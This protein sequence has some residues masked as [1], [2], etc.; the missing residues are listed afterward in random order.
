MNKVRS[1]ASLVLIASFTQCFPQAHAVDAPKAPAM[2]ELVACLT[3]DNSPFSSS[4]GGG[5]DVEVSRGIGEFLHRSIRISWITIPERGGLGKAL[6]QS[7]TVGNCDLFFGIPVTGA[8]N[9][10]VVDQRLETSEPYLSTGYVLIAAK[11]GSV[12]T[13][14]DARRVR[15]VGV[16]TATPADMFLHKHQF[17]RIPYGNNRDLLDALS[18]GSVNVAVLWLPALARAEQQGFKLWPNAIS[19]QILQ[20]P[21]LEARFVIA[22]RPGEERLKSELNAALAHLRSDGSLAS[23]LQR[24]GM[25][26]ANAQ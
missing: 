15:R 8:A 20:S 9:E 2:P 19:D 26:R 22:I 6:R 5:I 13:L 18:G 10:D 12:R 11:G 7:M 16:V 24:H 1:L 25:A 4:N 17:N 3:D 14:D 21:D 23:I